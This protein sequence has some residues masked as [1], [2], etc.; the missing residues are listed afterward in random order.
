VKANYSE[1]Q[2]RGIAQECGEF[3]HVI[4]AMGYGYSWLNVSA[5]NFVR[6]C[7]DCVN[8]ASGSCSIFRDEIKQW[9]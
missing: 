4:N 9:E 7:S 1:E 8:W 5:D 3:E 2:L 6:R